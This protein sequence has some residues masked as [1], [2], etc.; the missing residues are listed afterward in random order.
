[1]LFAIKYSLTSQCRTNVSNWNHS[2]QDATPS[3]YRQIFVFH[4]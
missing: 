2:P 4:F 1:M 3:H